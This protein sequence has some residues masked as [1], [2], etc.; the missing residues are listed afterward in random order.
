MDV[1][2]QD[3]RPNS[4]EISSISQQNENHTTQN[5]VSVINT[6]NAGPKSSA[7][8]SVIRIPLPRPDSARSDYSL[9]TQPR[10]VGDI[11]LTPTHSSYT[12]QHANPHSSLNAITPMA[13][14]TVQAK[15]SIKIQ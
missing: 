1:D 13:S 5:R 6:A 3:S 7:S 14:G 9:S 12:P 15:N 11:A 2:N 8:I 4:T 10:I